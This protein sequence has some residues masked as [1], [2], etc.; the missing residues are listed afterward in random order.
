MKKKVEQI[1]TE[2]N[3]TYFVSSIYVLSK[4]EKAQRNPIGESLENDPNIFSFE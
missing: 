2:A 4:G 3:S 1:A